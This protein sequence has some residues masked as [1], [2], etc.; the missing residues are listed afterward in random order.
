MLTP[1]LMASLMRTLGIDPDVV[2]AHVKQIADTARS[3]DERLDRIEAETLAIR[4]KL[5]MLASET[6]A[7]ETEHPETAALEYFERR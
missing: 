5:D 3:I 4:S 6:A 1:A 7:S 2:V